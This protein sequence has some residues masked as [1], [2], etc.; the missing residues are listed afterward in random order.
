MRVN[1]EQDVPALVDGQ[2]GKM[3]KVQSNLPSK[4]TVGF[5]AFPRLPWEEKKNDSGMA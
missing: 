2:P 1:P 5:V 4:V 3:P